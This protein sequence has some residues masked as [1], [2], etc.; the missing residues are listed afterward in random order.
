[1]PTGTSFIE[2]LKQAIDKHQ[3]LFN[4]EQIDKIAKARDKE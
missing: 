3:T 4:S 2:V 1:M